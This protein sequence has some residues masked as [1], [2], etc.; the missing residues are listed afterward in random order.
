MAL[1][2]PIPTTAANGTANQALVAGLALFS[3]K[4]E[5]LARFYEQVLRTA[6]THRVHEDGREHW[7][8]A[9]G[10]V[11]LEIKALETADGAPTSDSF[12]TD[13]AGGISRSELSFQVPSA[14][15]ASARAMVAGGRILQKATSY[16]WGTFGVVT[17][18]DGNRLGLF[19]APNEDIPTTEGQA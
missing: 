18:P 17:D 4:P 10:G 5:E 1:E 11:Q 7:I 12:G 2:T 14:S 13:A 6:F 15:A 3:T 19:E 16:D 8:V 9:M